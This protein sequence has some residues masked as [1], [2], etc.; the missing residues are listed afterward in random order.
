MKKLLITISTAL[1]LTACGNEDIY[2][3]YRSGVGFPDMRIHVATF[4]S[5]DSKDSKFK[6]YNQD[7]CQT[8]S[9][10]FQSKPN[11]SVRYWCEKGSFRK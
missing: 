2:T 5:D 7:N 6:T 11:V 3:L 1:F 8:A 9:G 4:N 10:L